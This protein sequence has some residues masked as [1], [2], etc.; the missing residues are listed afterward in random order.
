M[1]KCPYCDKSMPS[2]KAETISIK[3]APRTSWRGIAYCCPYCNAALSVTIDQISLKSDTV[4]EVL[5]G[6]G[7]G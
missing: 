3:S 5:R 2:I 1:A 6:L 4:G 7:K